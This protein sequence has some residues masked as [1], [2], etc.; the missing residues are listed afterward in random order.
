[1]TTNTITV[2]DS[3]ST[4]TTGQ[5]GQTIITGTPT[6]GSAASAVTSGTGAFSIELSGTW[7]GTVAFEQSPDGGVNWAACD[8]VIQGVDTV[9]QSATSNGLFKGI[10]A[11]NVQ[12]RARATAA[13][14]GSVAVAFLGN[15][16]TDLQHVIVVG[17][18]VY[19]NN[20]D[21]AALVTLA[22]HS[23]VGSPVVSADQTNLSARGVN[24][25][26]DLTTVTTATVTV[27]IQGKDAASGKYYTLLAGSAKTSAGTTLMTVYAGT[28]A[29][30]N[31]AAGVP[32]PKV[33]RVSVAI[34]DNGGTAAV[35]GTIG[36]SLT[37]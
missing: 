9:V 11:G 31:V 12:V 30:S 4:T 10:A 17:G 8:M 32:L 24:V 23:S 15:V 20:S 35:T 16:V 18:S 22:A 21:T 28:P 1:M 13:V 33:W 6:A 26:V 34:A 14:T 37:V 36:A 5:G 25:V 3:A 27:T 19:G 7:T 29:S 2:V